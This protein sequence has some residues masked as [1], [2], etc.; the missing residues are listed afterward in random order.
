MKTNQPTW[1]PPSTDYGVH[2]MNIYTERLMQ[3]SKRLRL[4]KP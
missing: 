4:E 2:N 1:D 3:I